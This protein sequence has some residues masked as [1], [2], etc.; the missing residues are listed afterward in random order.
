MTDSEHKMTIR[1]PRELHK[2]AKIKAVE[3][4]IDLSKVIRELLSLW[5]VGQIKIPDHPK[6]EQQEKE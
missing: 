3:S 1:I 6:G 4:E 5:V 2:A